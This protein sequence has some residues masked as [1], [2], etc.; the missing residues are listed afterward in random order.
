M[1][2]E[3]QRLAVSICGLV[4]GVGFRPFVFNLARVLHL[5]GWVRNNPHGV[6][7]EVEG[8]AIRLDEFLQ[9]LETSLPPNAV[10]QSLESRILDPIGHGQFEIRPSERTGEKVP[11][12]L[13]DIAVCQACLREIN[14]PSDRRFRYPFINCTHCGPRFSIIL[15]LPYDRVNTTM[16]TFKMCRACRTEYEDPDN[17]RFHAQ[18]IA[19]PDCGPHLAFLDEHGRPVA[20][21]DQALQASVD[22][23]RS[24]RIIAVKGLGGFHLMA[25]AANHDAVGALRKRKGRGSKPFAVM[26]A[27]LEQVRHTCRVSDL[28]A[29]LLHSP[30]SPIVLLSKKDPDSGDHAAPGNPNLGALLPYTPLHHLL[31]AEIGGPVIAT[32]GNRSEEP[33]CTANEEALGRLAGIAD[34]F[35]VHDR[36]IE[37]HVDDSIAW[38]VAGRRQILRRARGYAPLPLVSKDPLPSILAVGGHL[39]NSIALSKGNLLFPSQHIGDLDTLETEIAFEKVIGDLTS[40]YQIEATITAHDM[41]PD[42]GSTAFA[43]GRSAAADRVSV[44]HH[45]A[46]VFACMVE[47]ELDGPVLGISWDGT[48]YG[49]DGTIWGGEWFEVDPDGSHRTYTLSPFP[50]PGSEAAIREPRRSALGLIWQFNQGGLGTAGDLEC[51]SSFS[52]AEL[53]VLG[54]SLRNGINAPFSSSMGRLFDAVAALLDLC[55][56]NQYEGEAAMRLEH[57]AVKS[58]NRDFYTIN[59]IPGDGDRP[60][61]FD[62]HPMIGEILEEL[63]SGAD[64]C[65]IA[66][67]F[68][69]TLSQVILA[70]AQQV[71]IDAVVLTGGCFQNRLLTETAIDQLRRNGFHPYWHQRVPPNDGGIAVGQIIGAARALIQKQCRR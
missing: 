62:W 40:L 49:T 15:G 38:I 11:F 48:G 35:L 6:A 52:K 65:D 69:N 45:Q 71:D 54:Q 26:F 53:S 67:R 55:L 51:L 21:R 9:R 46:H 10:I 8:Q 14:T 16:R 30:G 23:I 3:I 37:R 27:D 70:T 66:K 18:P 56:L 12:M 47:N 13:P 59:L 2:R 31:L 25:D 68:H 60:G 61:A 64:R 1:G 19:C 22:A 44:Q 29:R 34:G 43:I 5:A 32:S 7:I 33:I 41:H 50:L 36:P 58:R 20:E 39:K 24:G 4:Q 63:R 28:E 17:R 42:Y 57:A